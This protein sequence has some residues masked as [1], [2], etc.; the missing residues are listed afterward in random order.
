MEVNS[1]YAGTS[2]VFARSAGCTQY[3]QRVYRMRAFIRVLPLL[4]V[5][6]HLAAC[7][8][9]KV[10]TGNPGAARAGPNQALLAPQQS[11]QC[12]LSKPLEGVPPDQARAAML[13]YEQQCYKQLA[14]REH[15]RLIALQDAAASTR[16]FGSTH[17]ALLERQPP[18]HCEPSK[19][20]A[21]LSPAEA[22]E[23]ALDAERQ[24][25]EQLEASERQK[26]DALQDALR[27]TVNTTHRQRREARRVR[28]EGPR[29]RSNARVPLPM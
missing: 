18:P 29:T 12:E 26:L 25:Y 20:S 13:D 15:A 11:P 24:C 22:R 3:I 28:C 16:S 23:A 17:R 21:G 7:A 5:A 9:N 14:E 19:P 1:C 10:A 6:A 2:G 4:A 8:A 27:K